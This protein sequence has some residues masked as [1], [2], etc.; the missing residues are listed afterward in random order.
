MILVYIRRRQAQISTKQN[1]NNTVKDVDVM[2]EG[3]KRRTL[4]TSYIYAAAALILFFVFLFIDPSSEQFNIRIYQYICIAAVFSI[5]VFAATAWHYKKLTTSEVIT[6]VLIIGL[7]IRI[8]YILYTPYTIRQHDVSGDGGH[9][10]YIRYIFTEWRLPDTYKQQYYHPPLHHFIS[11]CLLKLGQLLGFSDARAAEGIQVL[12]AFYS[13]VIM[14]VSCKILAE[15]GLKKRAFITASLIIAVHPSMIILSGSINNDALSV[16]FVFIAVLYAIRWYKD[17]TWKSIVIIALSIGLGM[18]TK[19]SVGIVAVAVAFIFLAKWVKAPQFYRQSRY[20]A[21]FG[22]FALICFPLALW[23][24]VYNLVRLGQPIGYVPLVGLPDLSEEHTLLQ[25]FFTVNFG[26]L[27]QSI[28]CSP[29]TD[30]N[31]ITYVFKCSVFGEYKFAEALTVP[32]TLLLVMNII[33][34]VLSVAAMVFVLIK[35][36]GSKD[37]ALNAAMFILWASN[38][39]S[40]IFFNIK[41]PYGCTMDFRYIVPTLIA[42]SYFLFRGSGLLPDKK[43]CPYLRAFVFVAAFM[44]SLSSVWFYTMAV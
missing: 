38:I 22:V 40:F 16:M 19:L 18:M 29:W 1:P 41:Y 37:R 25:R 8:Y 30:T 31:I 26:E 5:G 39:V 21:Q 20:Y 15:L 6:A 12:T 35:E 13:F 4:G 28:Y 9:Y 17:P 34:I 42:G 7:I 24:P 33:L 14:A 2:A 44:F 43:W 3:S 27:T 36:R 23:H 11:A 10:D 32:G